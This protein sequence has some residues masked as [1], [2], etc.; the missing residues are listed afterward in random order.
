MATIPQ[1]SLFEWDT[2]EDIGDLVRLRFVF[3][4][5]PDEP[6]MCALEQK[7]DKGRN[8]YPVR[9]VW[10]SILA[11][12]TFQHRTIESLRR[13]LQRNGQL[14]DLCGFD[15]LLGAKSV[16]P[17]YVYSRF[18]YSLIEHQQLIDQMFERMVHE[19][20]GL[21]DDFGQVLALDGKALHSYAPGSKN[22]GCVAGDHRGE[23]DARWGKHTYRGIDEKGTPWEMVKSWFGFT[24]HL[25]VD[26]NH[27]L[28]VGFEI[29]DASVNE[30]PVANLL[31][32]SV[33][34][35][36]PWLV[37]RCEYLCG[38]RGLDDGKL[39]AGAWDKY[40]IKPVIDIRNCWKD[41]DETKLVPGT[42]NVVYDFKG[43]VRCVCPRQ[44]KEREMGYGGF[45][46]E[47]NTHKYRCPARHYGY[48][49]AGMEGCSIT[50]SVRIPLSTDRRVFTPL[51][52]STYKW[53]DVYDKRTA[54]ERVNSRLA[55]SFGFEHHTIRGLHK[56]HF[57]I[58]ISFCVMLAIAIGWTKKERPELARSLLKAG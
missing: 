21:H 53:G 16:P 58:S 42:E 34:A 28:P 5:L 49:C 2:V 45:E 54:V 26:A 4:H 9:S 33:A 13:E 29:P 19:Y 38:D 55:T 47:R 52:R 12:V 1:T 6:L 11:G 14:R 20:G 24:L 31:L 39:V 15:P 50:H 3:E 37:D 22:H 43:T 36:Y 32:E 57:R 44:G 8:D 7:R 56:M 40:Q 10:N 30:M 18:L 27:E 23:H 41:P 48:E 25:V 51:A 35:D 17:S 46:K